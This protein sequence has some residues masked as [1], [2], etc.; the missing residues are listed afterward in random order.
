MTPPTHRAAVL[1]AMAVAFAAIT[2]G[3]W[4]SNPSAADVPLPWLQFA[5]LVTQ[6]FQSS[7]AARDPVAARF[8]AFL[9]D[10]ALS[11]RERPPTDLIVK[12]WFDAGGHVTRVEFDSLGRA[13]SDA[14]LRYLL[15]RADVGQ[16]PPTDMRQPLRVRISLLVPT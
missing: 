5:K 16:A 1:P 11:A 4:A 6:Q 8:H 9:E 3:L 2:T 10:A 12:A 15:K 14:D 13:Q 7:L